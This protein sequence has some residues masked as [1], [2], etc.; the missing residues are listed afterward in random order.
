MVCAFM[1]H[2][3]FNVKKIPLAATLQLRVIQQVRVI[4]HVKFDY[5]KDEVKSFCI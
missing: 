5:V 2:K 3:H 1:G 4:F